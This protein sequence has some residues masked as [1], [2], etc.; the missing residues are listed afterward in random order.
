MGSPLFLPLIR[1][2]ELPCISGQRASLPVHKK[3]SP[4]T[5]RTGQAVAT[6]LHSTPFTSR[7]HPSP[8]PLVDGIYTLEHTWL[9]VCRIN[10]KWMN[11][12]GR[13]N[14]KMSVVLEW[15]VLFNK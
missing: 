7:H 4:A 2:A 14:V 13:R 1:V 10:N 8:H 9:E 5:T 11:T 12:V 15:H 3:G 6:G